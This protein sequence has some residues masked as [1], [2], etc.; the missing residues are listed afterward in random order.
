[1]P[2]IDVRRIGN[3]EKTGDENKRFEHLLHFK[4][5]KDIQILG[6][7]EEKREDMKIMNLL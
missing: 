3:L 6:F 1:M 7:Q 5:S 4:T 2:T